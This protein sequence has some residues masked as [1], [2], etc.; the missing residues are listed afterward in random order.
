[1]Y[2]GYFPYKPFMAGGV[3]AFFLCSSSTVGMETPGTNG[4]SSN[5]N[6]K[7]YCSETQSAIATASFSVRA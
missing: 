7:L 4:S 6:N 5:D 2:L 1:M 3:S